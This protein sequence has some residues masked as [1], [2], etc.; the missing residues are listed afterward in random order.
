MINNI[1]N[2]NNIKNNK[3]HLISSIIISG[4]ILSIFFHYI[5]GSYLNSGYP[6]NTFLFEPKWHFNDFF[7]IYDSIVCDHEYANPYFPFANVLIYIISFFN[8]YFVFIS[9]MLIFFIVLSYQNY[10]Y[11]VNK[12]ENKFYKFQTFIIFTF[13]SYPV[14]YTVDRGNIEVLLYVFLF[15]FFY[16]Y[17]EQKSTISSILFLSLAISMKLYPAV[18]IILLV[19][20]KKYKEALYT[21]LTSFIIVILSYWFLGYVVYNQT[22]AETIIGHHDVLK[23]FS[24]TCLNYANGLHH[25]HTLW[26][27]VEI[28]SGFKNLSNL[29]NIYLIFAIVIFAYIS[30]YVISIENIKWKKVALLIISMIIFPYTSYDYTLIHLYFPI[31]MFI[32]SDNNNCDYLY[33][34]FFSILLIPLAYYYLFEDI[35][36]STIIYT[37]VMIII[38]LMI[39][40]NGLNIKKATARE[41]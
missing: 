7:T 19:S 41:F 27:L 11:I 6:Y 22:L 8:N 23:Y 32:N 3:V 40:V 17:Y 29:T 26:V 36:V 12:I 28:L 16:Y 38:I 33:A 39:I 37:L 1:N 30:Y 5:F 21:I 13:I 2:I 4:F 18:L 10:H 31:T 15:F 34:I 20:D 9:M 25:N 24:F 35:S 14:L